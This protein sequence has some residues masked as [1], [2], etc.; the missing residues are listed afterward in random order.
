MIYL[1]RRGPRLKS[2]DIRFLRHPPTAVTRFSLAGP[3]PPPPSFSCVC[4]W[5]R[6]TL[7]RLQPATMKASSIATALAGGITMLSAAV[8]ADP[9]MMNS[10]VLEALHEADRR[11]QELIGDLQ[12]LKPRQMGPVSHLIRSILVDGFDAQ[13][14]EHYQYVPPLRSAAC[15][16]D[17][18]CVWWY[19]AKEMSQLFRGTDGQCTDAA[20]GAIRTGFHDAGAWSKTTG[21]FGGADGSIVHAP[22][23][24][25]RRPNKGLQ[26]IVQQYKFWY[27]R[28]SHFGVSMADL[29]QMGANVAT[30][31]CPLG[32]RI[33]SFVGR[34]DNFKPA[35]DG[36]L[37][38]PFDP[39]DKV[40]AMFRAKTIQPLSLA[41]LLG[42]HS[43]SRQRFFNPARAGAPQDSTPGVCDV[44]FYR[45]TLAARSPP[46]VF[47][48][49]SDVVLA[50]HP[51]LF[52][53]FKAF[54]GPGGQALW[55]HEY[56]RAY[57]RLSL[58]GVFN[59]NNLTDCTRVLPPRT[60]KW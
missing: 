49:P 22:E 35:P 20:R 33:R 56:A 15:A 55:A 25:L 26:E 24:M 41:A 5:Y 27:D 58:L 4:P 29:I 34:R 16:R 12:W 57:L 1:R 10:S 2:P 60:L 54:A 17:T 8:Q 9:V 3:P 47:R 30:V 18:C 31:V 50:E 40:V 53:A 38:S 48:L 44:L 7:S 52:P 37:P 46:D 23:E 51:L 21:D 28:W 32:P 39:P 19:I 42:A 45:Q 13:S 43:T 59:I 6:K 36:L 14:N 11:P